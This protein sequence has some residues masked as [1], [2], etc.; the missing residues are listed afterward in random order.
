[1]S[2]RCE[3]AGTFQTFDYPRPSEQPGLI[4]FPLGA[5]ANKVTVQ[6]EFLPHQLGFRQLS[7]YFFAPKEF[8]IVTG[9]PGTAGQLKEER[10]YG[11]PKLR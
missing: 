5:K 10:T 2:G 1:M 9:R 7:F 3:I 6:A 8:K 11:E 4:L